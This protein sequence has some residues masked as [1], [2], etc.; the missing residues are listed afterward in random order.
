[1]RIDRSKAII[2]LRQAAIIKR[3]I[4]KNGL[5]L[6]RQ[7]EESRFGDMDP[8]TAKDLQQRHRRFYPLHRGGLFHAFL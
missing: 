5:M 7:Q 2:D 8:Y 6:C 1:M 3:Q 4:L